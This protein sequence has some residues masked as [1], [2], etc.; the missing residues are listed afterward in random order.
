MSNKGRDM[1]NPRGAQVCYTDLEAHRHKP[2]VGASIA[3]C[4]PNVNHN[5]E[6]GPHECIESTEA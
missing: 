2:R 5:I 1:P 3:R 6:E 4:V